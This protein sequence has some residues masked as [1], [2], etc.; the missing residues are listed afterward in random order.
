MN[1]LASEMNGFQ[2]HYV[3]CKGCDLEIESVNHALIGCIGASKALEWILKW[4]GIL[5][6]QFVNVLEFLNFAANWGN[7]PRKQFKTSTV[8]LLFMVYVEGEE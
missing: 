5:M 3:V 2:V 1:V 7:F 8:L 4:R 6:R